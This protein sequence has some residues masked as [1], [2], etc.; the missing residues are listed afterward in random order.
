MNTGKQSVYGAIT[1]AFKV[2]Y[3]RPLT[4]PGMN[5]S[6]FTAEYPMIRW[7]EANG[8]DVSYFAGV[9]TDRK[10]RAD[11]AAQNL[12]VSRHDE[13]WSAT[14]RQTSKLPEQPE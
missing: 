4:L 10:R 12:Y 6:L 13:Y 11:Q 5:T 8:Y 1:R 7:L 14:T 2:S 3:N 9:D